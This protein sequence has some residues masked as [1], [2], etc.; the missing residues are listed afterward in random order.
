MLGIQSTFKI[1]E[2]FLCGI[3]NLNNI[4]PYMFIRQ[5]HY[6]WTLYQVDFSW[7]SQVLIVCNAFYQKYFLTLA[8]R[9]ELLQQFVILLFPN[10]FIN[11]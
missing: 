2:A 3:S 1:S 8:N 10:N 4:Y 6:V 11:I 5:I 7:I 9:T